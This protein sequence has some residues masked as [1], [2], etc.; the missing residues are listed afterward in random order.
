M[1]E[2]IVPATWWHE[3]RQVVAALAGVVVGFCL[4]SAKEWWINRRQRKAHWAALE[5]EAEICREH[6]DIYLA[7][8]V[9][10]PSYRLPTR[11]FE[12]SLPPLLAAGQL[13]AEELRILTEFFLQVETFNR[14][15]D[16]VNEARGDV[17][18]LNAEYGRNLLKAARLTVGADTLYTRAR[19]VLVRRTRK[20]FC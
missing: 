17:D 1:S 9:A 20:T 4:L 18:K 6:A 13:G 16:Q 12:N 8:K 5:T 3:Y 15:L 11:A 14:G 7:D 2:P 19:L 10:A